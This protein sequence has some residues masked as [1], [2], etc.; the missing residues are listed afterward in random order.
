[1]NKRVFQNNTNQVLFGRVVMM[2]NVLDK[3]MK[4]N[5]EKSF[6]ECCEITMELIDPH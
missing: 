6:S 1:M 5:S 4:S 3:V 2:K